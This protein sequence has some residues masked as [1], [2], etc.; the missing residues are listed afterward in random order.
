V[1]GPNIVFRAEADAVVGAGH[2]LRCLALAEAVAAVEPSARIAFAASPATF[3]ALPR[4]NRFEQQGPDPAPCA[5]AVIDGYGFDAALE[6]TWR[7]TG[8]RVAVLEDAPGRPHR[9]DLLIDPAPQR[10][11][12]DYRRAAPG[13]ELLLGL[14]YALTA[15]AFRAARTTALARRGKSAGV[16]RLLVSTGLGDAGGGAVAALKALKDLKFVKRI[17]VAVGRAAPSLPAL[18]TLAAQDPRVRLRPDAEDMAELIAAAD[19]AIGA[20]GGSAW[21]RCVLGLPSLV[22]IAAGNQK[23]NA[24]ALEAAGAATVLGKAGEVPPEAIAAEVERLHQDAAARRAMARAAAGL[25]DGRGAERAARA[26]LRLLLSA[27]KT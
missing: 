27:R 4:L 3:A 22:L 21:E 13:A 15:P 19:L 11:A 1:S 20:A 7:R 9:C 18:R 16:R 23:D 14:R 24:A 2:A 17:D 10:R 5:L 12:E 26:L 25:V 8:A 6:E